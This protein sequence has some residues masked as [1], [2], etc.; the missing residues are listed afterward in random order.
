[1]RFGNRAKS[2]KNTPKQNKQ[3]S[4]EELTLAL[5]VAETNINKL[6]LLVQSLANELKKFKGD[7][8]LDHL[9]T[10]SS[11]S[12]TPSLHS[13]IDSNSPSSSSGDG[14]FFNF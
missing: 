9:S 2:I 10:P 5:E 7:F 3:R 13:T 14:F 8:N 6:N 12:S 1:L 4:V 11:S